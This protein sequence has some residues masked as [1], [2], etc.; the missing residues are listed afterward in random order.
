MIKQHNAGKRSILQKQTAEPLR[1][2]VVP[3]GPKSKTQ[4]QEAKNKTL[5]LGEHD[6]DAD[7]SAIA[8]GTMQ[9]PVIGGKMT[10]DQNS[11]IDFRNV[12]ATNTVNSIR[13]WTIH[14]QIPFCI[15]EGDKWVPICLDNTTMLCMPSD[16]GTLDEK[17][18]IW[19]DGKTKKS[20]PGCFLLSRTGLYSLQLCLGLKSNL[21]SKLAQ[22]MAVVSFRLKNIDTDRTIFQKDEVIFLGVDSW[23]TIIQVDQLWQIG[24]TF[25]I[26]IM[27]PNYLVPLAIHGTVQLALLQSDEQD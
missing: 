12:L 2:L 24:D 16:Q 22:G 25:T 14:P 6:H 11:C 8:F 5:I 7:K 23:N 17:P 15:K 4:H 10:F 18:F 1:L 26:E 13:K 3:Q 27:L 9:S 19:P 21:M 20:Q